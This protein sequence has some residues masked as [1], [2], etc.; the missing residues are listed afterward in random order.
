MPPARISVVV[1]VRNEAASI[2][3]LAAAFARQTRTPDEI[4]I[5][6]GGS[7]DDT[8][9]LVRSIVNVDPRWRLI[10]AGPATPGRARNVGAR[11]AAH[12]WIAFTDAGAWPDP[13]WLASLAR[14]ADESAGAA[15]VFGHYEPVTDTF[16]TQCAALAYVAPPRSCAGGVL[17]GPSTASMLIRRDVW[18]AA[19]GF[20]DLRAG[21]D[22]VFFDAIRA[23]GHPTAW[24]PDATVHWRLQPTLAATFRRFRAY[25]RA[26]AEA[27]LQSRWHYGI[28]RYYVI[29]AALALV[30]AVY[31][32]RFLSAIPALLVA[33]V[34]RSIWT[35][36]ARPRWRV[37][38][39]P[40]VILTV[41]A[42]RITIDAATFAG[43]WDA[44]HIS[45]PGRTARPG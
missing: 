30:A 17:R 7:D 35:R 36:A 24:A 3:A 33:R 40:A 22:L 6:D 14:A 27:R 21:E 39:N 43:W 38:V 5:V 10:C 28:L 15:V 18:D 16:F 2:G 20:P 29:L 31:D 34:L 42:I 12:D 13:S 1:P 44:T 19:G 32:W 37:L 45:A 8:R 11:S 41:L 9:E 4:V 23:G 26:N 25:S